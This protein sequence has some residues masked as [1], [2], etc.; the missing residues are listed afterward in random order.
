M[1][2]YA[3]G[4]QESITIKIGETEAKFKAKEN[5][6]I[7][8]W[9]TISPCKQVAIKGLYFIAE[10]PILFTLTLKEMENIHLIEDLALKKS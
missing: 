9:Y 6:A 3:V 2:H 5:I 1:S 8:D 7:Y 10:K 4:T